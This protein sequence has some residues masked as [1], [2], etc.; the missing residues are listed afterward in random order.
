M[1]APSGAT[2]LAVEWPTPAPVAVR[3]FF[4]E[5]RGGV[6]RAPF[7]GLN[8]GA[9]VGDDPDAV[10]R[11]RQWLCDAL[12][13]TSPPCWLRQ[14]HG[15]AVVRIDDLPQAATPTA[16]AAVATVPGRVC[17]L[18]TA[19]CLPVLLCDDRGSVVAAAHAGWRGLADG[20]IAATVAAMQ[21]PPERLMAW[22][23]P[24]ISAAAF[25]VGDE[26]RDRFLAASAEG[27]KRGFARNAAGRWQADLGMLA[28]NQLRSLGV[29]AI[30]RHRACTHTEADR[31]FSYRRDGVCG[32]QASLIWLA[33]TDA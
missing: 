19:D 32:R 27:A 6:S 33:P 16:D 30:R 26:V 28:E 22:L 29:T 10:A 5:R 20:V 9:H 24:A 18:L 23:G 11:N 13:L 4:T 2:P 3:A 31:F 15:T 1:S 8:L 17:A 25:E 14:V 12:S 7:D 21:C